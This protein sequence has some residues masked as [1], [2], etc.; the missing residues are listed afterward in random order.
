M[1]IRH[2]ASR[3]NPHYKSLK[4]LAGSARE[5]RKSGLTLLDGVH[6]AKAWEAAGWSVEEYLVSDGGTQNGEIAEFLQ[7]R[8][9]AS[10]TVFND[11]LFGD[12]SPVDT[13]TGLLSCVHARNVSGAPANDQDTVVLDG[14]QDPGNVGS[15]LRSAAAAGYRQAVLSSDCAHAWS[16]KTLRAG[17]GAQFVM[18]IFESVD[19]L[20]FLG[21]FR[22][23]SV[24]TTLTG[25]NDLFNSIFFPPLAWIFGHEG[26]GARPEVIAASKLQ[27]TIPMPG[28]IESLN[29]VAAASI[30]FFESVRRRR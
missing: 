1:P 12:L 3:E 11:A 25:Q 27:V 2:I 10:V 26:K 16:P 24:V 17:M 7:S 28:K 20:D 22:G 21:D 5:R 8:P 4:K 30:C 23:T 15:L 18:D 14:V 13:P 9:G 19:L 6:L 29:V